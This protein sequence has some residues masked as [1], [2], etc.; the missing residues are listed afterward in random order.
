MKIKITFL[1]IIASVLF[2][3]TEKISTEKEAALLNLLEKEQLFELRE[4]YEANTDKISLQADLRIQ[5]SL[6]NTF[7][8]NEE[9]NKAIDEL[10]NKFDEELPD[11]IK[12]DLIFLK[13]DNYLKLFDYKKA[14]E[15]NNIIIND[16][17][18]SMDSTGYSEALNMNN[19]YEPLVN[20]PPQKVLINNDSYI[21]LS[22]DVVGLMNVS[23]KFGQNNYDLIFDTGA[24]I[25]AI[26][27]S[28]AEEIGLDI[29]DTNIEGYAATGKVVKSSLA[30]SDSMFIG[31]I[32]VTNCVFMV[33]EDEELDFPQANFFPLGIIGFPVIEGMG[34][35]TITKTDTLIVKKERNTGIASNMRLDGMQPMVY[36]FNGTDTL[37]Y[38]FDTGATTTHFTSIYYEKYK[39]FLTQNATQDET[40]TTSAGGRSKHLTY[41]LDSTELHIGKEIAVLTNIQVH[42][43]ENKTFE[44][45]YGNLG[46]DLIRQFDRL[47]LNFEEM[48]LKFDK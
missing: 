42:L 31:D 37:E 7:N 24:G 16:Y 1:A 48:F 3:C 38:A 41:R 47:I 25:S 40:S 6:L 43:D 13:T 32:M 14:F 19:M 39:D 22:R 27:R 26:K 45:V 29:L 44:S 34:E 17:A 2:S 36:L 23:V 11:S 21:P 18:D 20:T 28:F 4:L 9:S 8:K 12:T 33:L 10:L 5:A 35:I 46:Q 15:T 30:V